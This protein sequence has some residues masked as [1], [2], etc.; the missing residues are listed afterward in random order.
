MSSLGSQ[1]LIYN[2]GS[3]KNHIFFFYSVQV[4]AITKFYLEAWEK[5]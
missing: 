1:K 4:K 5:K 3:N 2:F